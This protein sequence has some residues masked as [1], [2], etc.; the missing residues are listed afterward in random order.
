MPGTNQNDFTGSKVTDL[1]INKC[2]IVSKGK[3]LDFKQAVVEFNYYEDMFGNFTSMSLMLVDS[4][5]RHNDM[6]WSGDEYLL[7]EANKP[8]VEGIPGATPLKGKFRFFKTDGRGLTNDDNENMIL[9][10]VSE[11]AYLSERM[12]ISKSYKQKRISEIVKDIAINFLQIPANEFP[13]A[14]IEKT[15]G[16][17][18]IVIPLWKPLEAINWLCTR[19]I[20]DKHGPDSGAFYLFWKNRDGYQFRSVLSLYEDQAAIER[21]QYTNPI[22]KAQIG[23]ASSGYWYGIKNADYNGEVPWDPYEQIIS[24]HPLDTFDTFELN[25]RGGFSNRTLSLDYIKRTHENIDFQYS[26]YWEWLNGNILMYK[27]DYYNNKP[28]MDT[29]PDK[30]GRRHDD[31]KDS[32]IKIHPA[33]GDNLEKAVPYR[34]A[35][36]ALIGHN[37]LKMLIPGDPYISVGRIIYIHMPQTA[38]DADGKK[39][40]D[41]FLSGYYIVSA[42][43]HKLDQ[44]NNFETTLEVV[45]D[46]YTGRKEQYEGKAGLVSGADNVDS[47]GSNDILSQLTKGWNGWD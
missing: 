12:K 29:T 2:L 15:M 32:T 21:F 9:N 41:R 16:L 28:I 39:L 7:F 6:S 33:K 30:F 14:N 25:Q 35:Q 40:Y 34:Y 43:R 3:T 27:D 45:K 42:L 13:D 8:G 22:A 5:G 37:R 18:D 24:H 46:S 1:E 11:D 4:S 44:E 20:S 47:G 10:C 38:K 23:G 31:Y 19:A 17:H 36:L 26:K